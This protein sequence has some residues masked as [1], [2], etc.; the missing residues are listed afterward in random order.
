MPD[1]NDLP[2]G[3]EV[4]SSALIL[5]EEGKVLLTQSPVKWKG[6][7]TIPGGHVESGE[8]IKEAAIREGEEETG[9]KLEPLEVI[10]WGELISSPDFHRNAHFIFFHVV[11]KIIGG[12]LE[13][14]QGELSNHLWVTPEEALNQN[15]GEGFSQTFK[16]LS[17]Y[18]ARS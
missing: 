3:I 10:N 5:N 4:V 6:K 17:G 16:K 9:Y 11:C 12:E 8:T 13:I 14:D 1:G 18:L 7:W 2:R 15:L